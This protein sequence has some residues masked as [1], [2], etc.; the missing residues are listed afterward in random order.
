MYIDPFAQNDPCAEKAESR[1][2][3]GRYA[4][5]V[6]LPHHGGENDSIISTCVFKI[7]VPA[8]ANQNPT[9]MRPKKADA[10]T[11]HRNTTISKVMSHRRESSAPISMVGCRAVRTVALG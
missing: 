3:L 5:G 10:T 2:Y 1:H 8:Y 6:P 7:T 11:A 9:A 4:R